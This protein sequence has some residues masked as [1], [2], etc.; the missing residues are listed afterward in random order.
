M[1]V[2]PLLLHVTYYVKRGNMGALLAKSKPMVSRQGNNKMSET[3]PDVAP[4][5]DC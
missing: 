4:E 5:Q 2:I 3:K 1:K